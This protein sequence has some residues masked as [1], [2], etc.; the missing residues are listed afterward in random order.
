MSQ[1]KSERWV[2]NGFGQ[3]R[4][5]V[6]VRFSWTDRE[7]LSCRSCGPCQRVGRPSMTPQDQKWISM[8]L[9]KQQGGGGAK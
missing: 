9:E 1:V 8:I 2:I 5:V 3:A 4:E 7:M 6:L